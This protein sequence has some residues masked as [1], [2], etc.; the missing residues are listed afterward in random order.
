MTS[1]DYVALYIESTY[2]IVLVKMERE[3]KEEAVE[4][5]VEGDEEWESPQSSSS[6]SDDDSELDELVA[7]HMLRRRYVRLIVLRIAAI[8]RHGE[9]RHVHT[10]TLA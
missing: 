10:H 7:L 9:T 5:P 8:Y 1:H 6:E 2:I 3:G 4:Q